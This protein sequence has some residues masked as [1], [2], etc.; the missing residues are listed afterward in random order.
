MVYLPEEVE[1]FV[2]ESVPNDFLNN[3]WPK[4]LKSQSILNRIVRNLSRKL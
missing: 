3:I 4:V 2:F 1:A